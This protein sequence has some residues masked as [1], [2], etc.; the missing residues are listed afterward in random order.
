VIVK[1]IFQRLF[2]GKNKPS[3]LSDE[4]RA[5]IEDLIQPKMPSAARTAEISPKR[6]EP[7]GGHQTDIS[8]LGMTFVEEYVA[9]YTSQASSRVKLSDLEIW[10]KIQSRSHEDKINLCLWAFVEIWDPQGADAQK[11]IGKTYNATEAKFKLGMTL[12]RGKLP[13]TE[14]QLTKLLVYCASRPSLE[15]ENPVKSVLGGVERFLDGARPSGELKT[16]LKRILKQCNQSLSYSQA[17]PL[18]KLKERLIII[19]DPSL[20]ELSYKLP[21]GPWSLLVNKDLQ[22]LAVESQENWRTLFEYAGSAKTS[23]PSKKWLKAGVEKID[24]VGVDIFSTKLSQWMSQ[25][26]FDPAKPDAARDVIKGLVWLTANCS[27]DEMA[28]TVGRFAE[29]CFVKVPG[30]G[31][32]SK[33]I[34]NACITVLMLMPENQAAV[35]QLVRLREKIKYPSVRKLIDKR[36]L[37]VAQNR[38][39]TVEQLEDESLPTFGFDLTGEKSETFG[40]YIATLTLKGATVDLNWADKNGKPRKTIPASV[41]ANHKTELKELK[42]LAKDITAVL[43]GQAKTLDQSYVTDRLWTLDAWLK[44][45]VEHPLRA[46][47]TRSLIWEVTEKEKKIAVL[48]TNRGL[49]DISGKVHKAIEG[50]EIRLWHPLQ[51]TTEQILAWRSKIEKLELVQPFKQAHREVYV[52]TDAERGTNIYSNRFAAHIIRQHQFK[53][54]CAARGW[55]YTLQGMWD[56]W[57]IPTRRIDAHGINVQFTV[58]MIE[59]AEQT[60]SGIP[61]YLNTDQV[62]FFQNHAEMLMENIPPIIFSEAMRDVDLF[63]AVTSVASD[64][65]WADGGPEGRFGNYWRARAFG[66]L[67]ESA[68][69]RKEIIAKLVPKLVFSDKLEIGEKVLKVK[70]TRH[71]YHIHFGSGNIMMMPG[72]TYLCIVRASS[73]QKEDK[74]YLPFEGDNLT[75]IILSKAQ[76]LI[77]DDKIKDPTILSQL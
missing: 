76:M 15:W 3:A 73:G 60:T 52:V 75:S 62:R 49:E 8:K 14:D 6:S 66:D 37:E 30:I 46:Q 22:N 42:Q 38:G 25:T 13:Y 64:P 69:T 74:I 48:P 55:D 39:L 7:T 45:Y 51:S 11:W 47:M 17:E 58:N 53:A 72:N 1:G 24:A 70:G 12:V 57:N 65:N 71:E 4:V 29:M 33:K 18:R 44:L 19:L 26:R 31:A 28:L 36:L 16:A 27:S 56:S 61:L 20:K 9:Q 23:K 40:D 34:G 77:Q 2:G 50:A 54:L 32:R 10:T 41:K 68:K 67:G 21:N 43:A 59:D 35:A 5:Q 63:V